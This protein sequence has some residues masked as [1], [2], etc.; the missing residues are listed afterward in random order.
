M[1][2][3]EIVAQIT[4]KTGMKPGEVM[5]VVEAFMTTAKENMAKGE[6]IYLRGF[7]TFAVKKRAKKIARNISKNQ[8]ITIPAHFVPTFKPADTFK[9]MIKKNVK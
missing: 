4:K 1:T 7:G 8:S 2:K 9:N 3:A 6:N 5:K